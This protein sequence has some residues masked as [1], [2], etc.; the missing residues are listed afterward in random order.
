M[1]IKIKSGYVLREVADSFLIIAV[2]ER[3]KEFNGVVKLNSTSAFIFEKLVEGTT[4]E[5]LVTAFLN[6]YD[7]SEEVAK[8]DVINTVNKFKEAGLTE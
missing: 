8:L 7:V 6:E 3:A 1:K 5:Q 4:I 2:G